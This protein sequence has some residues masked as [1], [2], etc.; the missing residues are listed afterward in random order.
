M[1][2]VGAVLLACGARLQAIPGPAGDTYHPAV[3][4]RLREGVRAVVTDDASRV[5]LVRFEFPDGSLWATP[6]GGVEPGE[7]PEA[8][9]RRELLEEVGIDDVVLGP[10]IW[11][12]THV[13]PLS[14]EFDGQHEVIFLVRG[15]RQ[16]DEPTM[17][18]EELRS[19]GLAGARWWTPGELLGAVGERFAPSRL[20]ELYASLLADGPPAEPID[21][22]F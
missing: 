7:S 5:L 20:P 8:A 9:I 19:E 22:G 10:V 11:T 3:V 2:V 1:P 16:S 18:P 17:S 15:H 14:A 12:R 13:F 4:P 6:G 21:V